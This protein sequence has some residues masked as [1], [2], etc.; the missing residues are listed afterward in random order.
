MGYRKEYTDLLHREALKAMERAIA[1]YSGFRVGAALLTEDNEVFRGCNI[2]NPSLMMS[3][4]AEKVAL[5][6]ALSEGVK[7]VRA[8][9]VVSSG[10]DYCYPCGSCRQLIHE[11]APRAE[12]FV[13]GDKG[14]RKYSID[15]L[16]P[17][18]FKA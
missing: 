11:F 3:E 5:V 10:G 16:L 8:I 7:G 17:H 14:I 4:C 13:A 15:E 18:A 9:M 6:K 1:P 12:I 2:E